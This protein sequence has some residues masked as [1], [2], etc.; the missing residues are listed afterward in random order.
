MSAISVNVTEISRNFSEYLNRVCYAGEHFSLIRG[1]KKIAEI[2]P[3][4]MYKTMSELP[5]I[6]KSLPS[7]S[8]EDSTDFEY[9][10]KEAKLYLVAEPVNPW[11]V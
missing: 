2:S 8:N 6:L 5:E 11:D 10:L 3:V 4:P 9:D 1:G 7:L